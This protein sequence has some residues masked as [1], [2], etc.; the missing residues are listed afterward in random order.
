MQRTLILA[1]AVLLA[2]QL[3]KWVMLQLLM[4]PPRV[5][6]VT[7]FF[8][9]VLTYNTGVSFG[10]FQGDAAWKPY[11]LIAVNLVVS[12]GLLVWLHREA[13]NGGN[14]GLLSVAVGLVVGGALGNA[15]DRLHLPGVADFLDFH[16]AGWHW[17][18]FNLADSAIVCGVALIVAD[19]LFQP[20]RKSNK[21]R[22]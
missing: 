3:S 15:V 2:D 10:M 16:L 17:P 11:F 18:A 4:Q 6:E 12:L 9:L 1:A 7:G 19:G 13:R 8:N 20:G 5:I 21:G 14:A 22:G